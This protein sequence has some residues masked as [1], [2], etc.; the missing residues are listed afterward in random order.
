[1]WINFYFF[2]TKVT[3]HKKLLAVHSTQAWMW[4]LKMLRTEER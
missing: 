3:S 2:K 1:M 4:S